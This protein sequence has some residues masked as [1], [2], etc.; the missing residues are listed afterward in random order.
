MSMMLAMISPSIWQMSA[1]GLKQ[2]KMVDLHCYLST[3]YTLQLSDATWQFATGE[4]TNG[5]HGLTVLAF[6]SLCQRC[7]LILMVW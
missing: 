6:S 7:G 1:H 3:D 4:R 2:I 5:K